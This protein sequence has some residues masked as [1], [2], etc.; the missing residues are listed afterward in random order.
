MFVKLD[1]FVSWFKNYNLNKKF[2]Y[3]GSRNLRNS[4]ANCSIIKRFIGT[5]FLFLSKVLINNKIRDTQCG[6]K[7]YPKN[8]ALKVF[9]KLKIYG[10]SHD[11]EIINL[12]NKYNV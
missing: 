3:F 9:Q 2:V 8:Y 7:L 4:K 11:L 12:L 10:F 5:I 6:Y 1:F